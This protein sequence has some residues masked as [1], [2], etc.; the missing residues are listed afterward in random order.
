MAASSMTFQTGLNSR[1]DVSR[2]RLVGRAAGC[3][4]EL[5]EQ[6]L[7]ALGSLLILL[8]HHLEELRRL[9]I[10]CLAG[11]ANVL[12]NRFAAFAGMVQR[13]HQVILQILQGIVGLWLG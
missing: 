13:A 12:I 3:A 10:P 4:A 5:I 1:R 7:C 2:Q 11:V 8:R 9:V 6:F